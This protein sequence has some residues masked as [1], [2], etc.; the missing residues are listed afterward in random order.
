MP[1]IGNNG[2]AILNGLSDFWLRFFKDLGD[3]EATYEGAAVLLGQTYLNLLSDVLNTS[4]DDVPLFKQEYYRLITIREDNVI[5]VDTGITGQ[6]SWRVVTTTQ[7]GRLPYLQNKIFEPTAGFDETLDYDVINGQLFFKT[8]PTNP[9]PD[10]FASRDVDVPITGT[11]S[12]TGANWVTSG[13]KKN[14]VLVVNKYNDVSVPATVDPPG[15]RRYRISNLNATTLYLLAG[16]VLPE[17]LTGYSWRIERKLTTGGFKTGLPGVASFTGAFANVT[18]MRV[19]E[20]SVW[21][22]DAQVDD[23]RLYTVYGHYFGNQRFSSEAYRSFIRGLMQLYVFGPVVDRIES[24]LNVMAGLPVIRDD[25]EKLLS[26]SNG[27]DD[28]ATDGSVTTNVFTAA[29]AT[30]EMGDVGGFIKISDAANSANIGTF[31]ILDVLSSTSVL[32]NNI[33]L[34]VPETGLAWEFSRTDLQ[35]V[36]TDNGTYEFPRRVPMRSDVVDPANL[37]MLTFRAFETLTT[38]A[39]VTDYLKDPEWWLDVTLPQAII[40]REEPVLRTAS[41]QL[42][43]NIVGPVG[44]F[45]IGDPGF[46]ISGGEDGGLVGHAALRS[47]AVVPVVEV[48]FKTLTVTYGAVGAPQTATCTF[49]PGTYVSAQSYL[50][51]LNAPGSWTDGV[52]PAVNFTA[53]NAGGV[54]AST[55]AVGPNVSL[56]ITRTAAVPFPSGTA[57]GFIGQ[58]HRAAFILMDRFLKTHIVSVALDG[59]IDLSGTL[60]AE[61]QK[62]LLDVKPAHV[63]LFFQPL[64]KFKDVITLADTLVK[65][66]PVVATTPDQVTPE[67]NDWLIGT[68]LLI[69]TG[70]RFSSLTGGGIDIGSGAGYLPVA[71]GG[72]DPTIAPTH[73]ADEPIA[74]YIDRAL[75][76]NPRAP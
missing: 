13:V 68:G 65:V 58:H 7:Y 71:I 17:S 25:G 28:A 43:P 8:D 53:D 40:A 62:V 26:Y 35:I 63:A 41:P 72:A 1:V 2:R 30:F 55:V 6:A 29:S 9:I 45:T 39:V 60:I 23:A 52:L 57:K 20:M 21:A 42:L 33:T 12:S 16:D 3:V 15:T 14:D 32:L 37:G 50:A 74:Y 70:W 34:F 64:T 49:P 76:V 48:L 19:R 4:I 18:N 36:V 69:G 22:V 46:Y 44:E 59:S 67:H 38:A 66:R 54:I 11:F 47:A 75:Y 10:R 5:Y 56:Q 24:A 31:Q 73:P 51:I 61:M 27:L